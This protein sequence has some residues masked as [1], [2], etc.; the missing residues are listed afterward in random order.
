MSRLEFDAIGKPEPQGSARAFVA[1]G[2][3]V[4]TTANPKMHHWRDII[5]WSAREAM[6]EQSFFASSGA[7]EVRADFRLQRPASV[8]RK[9][10]PHPDVKPDLDKLT[11]A[12]LDALSAAVFRDDAQVT[13]LAVSKRYAES[14]EQPGVHVVVLALQEGAERPR[15]PLWCPRPL[16]IETLAERP[17]KRGGVLMRGKALA[18]KRQRL[19][20]RQADVARRIPRFDD[21]SRSISDALLSQIEGEAIRM[22]RG[23]SALYEAALREA[24]EGSA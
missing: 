6:S 12:L 20:L 4:V 8:S 19:G 21:A 17:R 23:F 9:R 14:N 18:R 16:Q 24:S 22:P 10:R 11:R 2:R 5:T 1:G 3:A 13:L 15:A 7:V